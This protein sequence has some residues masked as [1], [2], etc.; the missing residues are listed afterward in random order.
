MKPGALYSGQTGRALWAAGQDHPSVV[1]CCDGWLPRVCA[2]APV[3]ASRGCIRS[4]ETGRELAILRITVFV[5]PRHL[6]GYREA[7]VG[8]GSLA[9]P[10]L[11]RNDIPCVLEE[12][13]AG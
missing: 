11:S 5:A 7:R 3:R 9:T 8:S 13:P 4:G 10:D 1:A 2:F 6:A 12:T